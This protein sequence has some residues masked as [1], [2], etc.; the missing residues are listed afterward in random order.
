MATIIS[1]KLPAG[2][3]GGTWS[4]TVGKEKIENL[5]H[6]ISADD[7][8][9]KIKA[10]TAGAGA[11][12]TGDVAT[13][14]E[15]TVPKDPGTVRA[16]GSGLEGP[17][18]KRI[19]L[20]KRAVKADITK[21]EDLATYDELRE[22]RGSLIRKALGGVIFVAPMDA[23]IPEKFFQDKNGTFADLKA[24]GYQ[25]VGHLAKGDGIT[26]GRETE[27]SEVESF[28]EAD[29]TRIDITKDSNS[30]TFKCQE[31][32]KTVLEMY[33]NKDLSDIKVDPD[34]GEISFV[35]DAQ[36][37]ARYRRVIYVAKDGNGDQAKFIIRVMPRA[38]VSEV[39]E[40]QWSNE[41]ELAYG[42]TMKATRDEDYGYSVRY[43]YGG[44]GMQNLY[45]AMG[46]EQA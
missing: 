2:A 36:P 7:L 5:A 28:G 11:T 35:N 19:A 32:N 44:P 34:T 3:T 4:L 40:D 13:G 17:K 23:D 16:A 18:S 20:R 33:Y 8:A 6:N 29:P 1:I 26:F 38:T 9:D 39:Q 46:F 41:A 37:D 22:V 21:S 45:E 27:Q 43:V 12:A 14:F 15:V 25:C 31:T 24:L 10:T 30:A 42:M